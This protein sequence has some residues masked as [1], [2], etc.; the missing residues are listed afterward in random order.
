MASG[1]P[2]GLPLLQA[3]SPDALHAALHSA[4]DPLRAPD[5]PPGMLRPHQVDPWRRTLAALRNYR[6]AL[7]LEPT[8]A[9]KTWIALAIAA[10]WR[11]P[12]LMIVPAILQPQWQ[13]TM[14]SAGVAASCWTHERLSRG[15][16]PPGNPDLVIIDEYHHFRT[17]TTR[18]IRT[19]APWLTGRHVLGCTAT[20]IVNRL[21]DLVTLLHL[22]TPLDLL[23]RDGLRRLTDL[24]TLPAPPLLLRRVLIRSALPVDAM[25][26]TRRPVHLPLT[27]GERHRV[28]RGEQLIERLHGSETPG[29]ATLIRTVL[30]DALRSSDAALLAALQ[31][32]RL[33]LLHSQDAGGVSRAALHRFA[34][35]QLDQLVLWDLM[36]MAPE[37][38]PLPLDDLPITAEAIDLLRDDPGG[39]AAWISS[40]RSHLTDQVPTICFTRYRATAHLVRRTLGERTAWVTGSA[41]GIGRYRMARHEV[42]GLFGP[43]AAPTAPS[44]LVTTDVA[45]EGLD[46]QRAGQVIHL[47]LPWTATGLRQREGRLLRP[48]QRHAQVTVLTRDTP[49]SQLPLPT[50]AARI[51]RKAAL[52]T[53]WLD[54]ITRRTIAPPAAIGPVLCTS[55]IGPP[56]VQV[57]LRVTDSTGPHLLLLHREGS[58]PWRIA[59]PQDDTWSVGESVVPDQL[60]EALH[61][62]LASAIRWAS[63]WL[64][65]EPTSWC[66]AF[67]WRVQHLAQRAARLR[68]RA[69]VAR[70]DRLLTWSCSP[71]RLADRWLAE[72]LA[73]LDDDA[74]LQAVAP[75]LLPPPDTAI[76]ITPL[77]VVLYRSAPPPLRCS[78]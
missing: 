57:A 68:D 60:P 20:P 69:A 15:R 16:L 75:A 44:L 35:Q 50:P 7:L 67:T 18:R 6:A 51:T 13:R 19:L 2:T 70:L 63:A 55:Y 8:G 30:Q 65:P 24:A 9:G 38:I 46:L 40:L 74:L 4:T 62:L 54:G 3:A 53:R 76:E 47:D 49:P 26:S 73:A 27:P 56:G 59:L 77:A 42:L 61:T 29:V 1:P 72:T 12:V 41:A 66:P 32:Y 10:V 25:A 48:G 17:P 5:P 22:L 71:P 21:D 23:Y 28:R 78:R 39:D 37:G 33:L 45:A 34:G 52:A 11:K 43:D 31:R 58:G 14:A 36:P 64:H